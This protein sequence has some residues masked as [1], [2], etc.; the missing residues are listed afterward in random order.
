MAK[1][2]AT[3]TTAAGS[4][5]FICNVNRKRDLVAWTATFFCQGTFGGGTVNWLISPDGGTTKMPLYDNSGAAITSTTTDNF[6]VN[7][8][9]GTT[10]SDCPKIY[11]TLAGSAGATVLVSVFDNNN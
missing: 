4:E 10:N 7:L 5:V 11:A 6:T 8:G 3:L 2:T 9:S 1:Y